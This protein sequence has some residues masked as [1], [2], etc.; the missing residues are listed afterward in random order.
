MRI[1]AIGLKCINC[2]K[3]TLFHLC[4]R[5]SRCRDSQFSPSV[6]VC[7]DY[8]HVGKDLTREVFFLAGSRIM[9]IAPPLPVVRIKLSP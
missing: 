6:S 1:N 4:S 8:E 3:S 9:E 7:Y 5:L 2:G